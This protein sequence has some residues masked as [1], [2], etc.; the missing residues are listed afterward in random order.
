[1]AKYLRPEMFFQLWYGPIGDFIFG[2]EP[3][4]YYRTGPGGEPRLQWLFA[5]PN[6]YGYFLAAFFPL[7][8][9][10]Y[11]Q[12]K[13]KNQKL[14]RHIIIT[15]SILSIILTLSR[16]AII[17]AILWTILLY[18]NTIKQH[19]K[20]LVSI[21]VATVIII[22]WL[23]I[24]KWWSTREHIIQKTSS[25]TY[26]I[27][28]P[29]GYGL[30]TA[31]PAVHH[32]GSILPENYYM[33]IAIDIGTIGFILLMMTLLAIIQQYRKE[34]SGKPY[35]IGFFILLVMGLLLHVFED[36]MVNYLFF[37]PRGLYLWYSS[38]LQKKQY[39][40]EE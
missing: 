23:S 15:I 6:N 9:A 2:Q 20:L 22:G 29:Q 17:G 33:Q 38:N 35:M 7:L 37:I 13:T 1:M 28:Q 25:I 12:K 31:G 10:H 18:R 26:I 21:I 30:G 27:Q 24:F 36:S 8:L 3:P 40:T 34:E 39:Q 32:N 5:W 14:L 16:T 19:K 4:M 11:T